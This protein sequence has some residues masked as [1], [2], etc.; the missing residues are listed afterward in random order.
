MQKKVSEDGILKL[1]A[2]L[3]TAI[4][5][6]IAAVSSL[7]NGREQIRVRKELEI[8]NGKLPSTGA[9]SPRKRSTKKPADW[10]APPDF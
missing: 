10:Y 4:P 1:V 7:R 2:M 8:R 6:T 9:A 3:A 5:A